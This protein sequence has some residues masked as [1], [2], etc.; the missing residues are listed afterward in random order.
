MKVSCL[1]VGIGIVL[2][3]ARVAAQEPPASSTNFDTLVKRLKRVELHGKSF[4]PEVADPVTY[5]AKDLMEISST[6]YGLSQYQ[7]KV[8]TA[9]WG[10]TEV[11]WKSQTPMLVAYW[12]AGGKSEPI[13]ELTYSTEHDPRKAELLEEKGALT[14]YPGPLA[15]DESGQCYFGLTNFAP[16]RIYKVLSQDPVKLQVTPIPMGAKCFQIPD[17]SPDNL[18]VTDNE[19][20]VSFSLAN[21][22]AKGKTVFNLGVAPDQLVLR[23][24][25]FLS[26]DT[27]LLTVAISDVINHPNFCNIPVVTVLVDADRQTIRLVRD[28]GFRLMSFQNNRLIVMGEKGENSSSTK[29]VSEITLNL[30]GN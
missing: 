11:P 22:K 2:G 6:A 1:F 26:A 7:G 16:G 24:S 14:M 23:G 17:F 4:H 9:G 19:T 29:T 20:V 3:L 18:F 25:V 27:V 13:V 12:D 21:P 15:F 10:D 5:T 8:A 30:G 28:G